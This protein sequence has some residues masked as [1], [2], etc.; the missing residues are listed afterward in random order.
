MEAVGEKEL[1]DADWTYCFMD[2]HRQ[3][4]LLATM[5]AGHQLKFERIHIRAKPKAYNTV[6]F[7]TTRNGPD[8]RFHSIRFWVELQDANRIIC[9]ETGERSCLEFGP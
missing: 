2:T 6:T 1:P 7:K 8:P 5:P 4:Y 3:P 9:D